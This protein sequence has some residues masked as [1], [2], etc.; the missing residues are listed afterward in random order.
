MPR[1]DRDSQT[2]LTPIPGQL[3]SL[4]NVPTGCVFNIR[5]PGSR[6][7]SRVG[8]AGFSAAVVSRSKRTT[9]AVDPAPVVLSASYSNPGLV[10]SASRGGIAPASS[11]G[12]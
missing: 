2:R 5:C 6:S 1:M 10:R 9:D 11:R 8:T 12:K 3:P 7:I 4:I